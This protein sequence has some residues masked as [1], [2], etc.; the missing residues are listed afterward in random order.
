MMKKVKGDNPKLKMYLRHIHN[1][2]RHKST[3]Q[4]G[5]SQTFILTKKKKKKVNK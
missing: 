1:Y 4:I 2:D 3:L 5:A